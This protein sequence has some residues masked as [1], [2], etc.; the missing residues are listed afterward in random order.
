MNK[1]PQALQL[2]D[3]CRAVTDSMLVVPGLD[4]VACEAELRR[5]HAENER[6][7]EALDKIE[8][9]YEGNIKRYPS[10]EEV[11]AAIAAASD[12]DHLRNTQ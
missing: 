10:E 6:L 5:L 8:Y 4:T 9:S 12:R 3:A 11:N 2:A 1:Q 7:L